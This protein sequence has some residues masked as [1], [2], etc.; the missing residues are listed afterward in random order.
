[1]KVAK[2]TAES[3]AL[4]PAKYNLFFFHTERRDMYTTVY[5]YIKYNQEEKQVF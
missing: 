2:T 5:T 4:V 1:M 3:N